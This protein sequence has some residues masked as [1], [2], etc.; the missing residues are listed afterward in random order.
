MFTLTTTSST[1]RVVTSAA[2]ALDVHATFVDNTATTFTPERQNTAITTA[3][4][5][6]VVSAPAASTQRGI[7]RL[8]AHAL[9]GPIVVTVEYFDGTTATRLVSVALS[10]GETL[11]YEDA[12]GWRVLTSAQLKGFGSA[13][14]TGPTGPIG[15]TGDTGATGPTGSTGPTGATGATGSDGSGSPGDLN[16]I[17]I[18]D[19]WTEGTAILGTDGHPRSTITVANA[20]YLSGD[21]GHVAGTQNVP[22]SYQRDGGAALTGAIGIFIGP[23]LALSPCSTHCRYYRG[24]I[25]TGSNITGLSYMAFGLST[26]TAIADS[27][28]FATTGAFFEFNAAGAVST[29][30]WTTNT[31]AGT[32]TT[33]NTGVAFVATSTLLFE[34]INTSGT[35]WK[36]YINGTLVGTHTSPDNLPGTTVVGL[37]LKIR[38]AGTSG[39]NRNV[40][41]REMALK[42]V[43][44]LTGTTDPY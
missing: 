35:T 21:V 34:A 38:L 26:M 43:R 16:T 24:A 39:T 40:L 44:S 10:A 29:T 4:T 27:S 13:G 12:N 3:T 28:A 37:A 8:S 11:E 42:I 33:K 36:F 6:T 17:W 2:L 15:A 20:A 7:R 1:L 30:N 22:G 19:I 5:T 41:I 18:R 9:S 14:A 31:G 32:L 25:R 23:N